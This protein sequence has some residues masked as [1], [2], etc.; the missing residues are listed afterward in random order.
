MLTI[1]GSDTLEWVKIV[2]FG[3]IEKIEKIPYLGEKSRKPYS[4]FKGS[5]RTQFSIAVQNFAPD[6]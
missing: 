2:T 6:S 3:Y 5:Y 1:F 4:Y